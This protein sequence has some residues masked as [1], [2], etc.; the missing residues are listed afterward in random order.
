ML[1]YVVER[2]YI[3]LAYSTMADLEQ[4]A[5]HVIMHMW[6]IFLYYSS[7]SSHTWPQEFVHGL[8]TWI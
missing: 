6:F 8:A 3:H 2:Q 4:L 7:S 5:V 1:A